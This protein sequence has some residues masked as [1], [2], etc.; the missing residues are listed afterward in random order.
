MFWEL[1][2]WRLTSFSLVFCLGV[3]SNCT[4]STGALEHW[5]T[6]ALEHWGIGAWET[7]ERGS[8]KAW[9]V[10]PAVPSSVKDEAGASISMS[11]SM[12]LGAVSLALKVT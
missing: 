6:G 12:K 9:S 3:G 10:E 7:W 1:R 8:M 2:G 11:M 4:W 5:S